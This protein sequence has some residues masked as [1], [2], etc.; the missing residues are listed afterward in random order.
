MTR[1]DAT[2][3]GIFLLQDKKLW[4]CLQ[5]FFSLICQ[6]SYFLKYFFK[7]KV[8]ILVVGLSVAMSVGQ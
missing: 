8:E 3:R 7:I 1:L 4:F 6:F 2:P 5:I